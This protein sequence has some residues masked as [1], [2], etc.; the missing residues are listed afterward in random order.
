MITLKTLPQATAQ[1]V[2]DQVSNH[3]KVQGV[4][5][6][7]GLGKCRYRLDT[8]ERI[9]MC[10]AGCLMDD[11]ESVRLGGFSGRWVNLVALGSAPPEH[12]DLIQSLQYL[13]DKMNVHEW[14][15]ALERV[16]AVNDLV[17]TPWT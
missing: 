9:L 7:T 4:R 6:I 8:G 15:F 5:A 3:L 11:E 14:K 10:A 13:H 1:E 16:A 2:F 12:Q 17:F